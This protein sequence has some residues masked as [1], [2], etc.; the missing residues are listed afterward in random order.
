MDRS[1]ATTYAE[2]GERMALVFPPDDP[3]RQF[4]P[5]PSDIIISPYSKC[6]TTWLQQ[7]VHGLRTGGDMDFEDI[8]FVVP[9][10]EVSHLL[11]IDI[12]AEQKAEP[13][14]FKSHLSW[15]DVPK[16]ARYIVS[17]RDPKDAF[18]SLYRF[19]EGWMFEPGAISIE[20]FAAGRL[21]PSSG[22]SNYWRHL[23][24][25]LTQQGNPDV[26]LLAFEDMKVRL[27]QTV[28]AVAAFIG[29]GSDAL[30]VA[31]EQ[32]SFE[33]MKANEEPFID[34]GVRRRSEEVAGIPHGSD[35][36]KVRKG[37][38]GD[39]VTELPHSVVARFDEIWRDTIASSHPYRRY[40][41]LAE[42][43]SLA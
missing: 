32:A 6:G 13:R 17:V 3:W 28:E 40:E 18:L 27:R 2:L 42:T 11:G 39:H 14:A 16:G 19:L 26:L 9:W 4:R 29:V 36:T 20:E 31:T 38:A 5:R 21:D 23:D 15:H 10:I 22:A 33:F 12:D 37:D 24:S 30:D 8:S 41:D 7:I 43:L 35:S 34:H 1:R 25:W